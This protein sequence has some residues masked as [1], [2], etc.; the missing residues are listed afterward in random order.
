MVGL[1]TFFFFFFEIVL[2][3]EKFNTKKMEII[4]KKTKRNICLIPKQ[5]MGTKY[6][7]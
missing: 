4:N 3:I 1:E 7:H 2:R 5:K 6:K